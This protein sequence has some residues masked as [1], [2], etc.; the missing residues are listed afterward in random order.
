M[1]RYAKKRTD[2]VCAGTLGVT[3]SAGLTEMMNAGYRYFDTATAYKGVN[4]ALG[5]ALA[6]RNRNE[7]H[8]CVKINDGDLLEHHFSVSAILNKILADLNTDYLD[9]LMLHSPALL[10]HDRASE[11]LEEL[12]TLKQVGKIKHIGVSNFTV[13]ELETLDREYLRHISYNQIELH[14][15]FQQHDV[16][17]FCKSQGIEIMAY[18]PFG[19]GKA[20]DLL[21]NPVLT[22]I[23]S[24]NNISVHQ[25]IIAW[26]TQRSLIA[27]A[28][29]DKREHLEA[30]LAA[31]QVFLTAEEMSA[32]QGLDRKL[33]T[34][35]WEGFVKLPNFREF[36]G[37]PILRPAQA[38]VKD[39]N[40]FASK[41]AEDAAMEAA[42]ESGAKSKM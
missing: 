25:V 38:S 18:R 2:F 40:M 8:L 23:A 42:F 27:T 9:T 15:Y 22:D 4:A 19:K 12:I 24:R 7:F 17:R 3:T 37:K 41:T 35:T 39:F 1:L 11:L 29:S 10:L 34:C 33:Q 28:K 32:I 31:C 20:D 14:P 36:M 16:V 6:G 26:L 13:K 21:T 30:N 5:V